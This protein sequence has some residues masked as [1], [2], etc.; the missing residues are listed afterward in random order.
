MDTIVTTYFV[1]LTL[2]VALTVWV[3]HTLHKNGRIWSI[4]VT[5]ARC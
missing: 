3:G 1:Y 2:S 5:S 4:S